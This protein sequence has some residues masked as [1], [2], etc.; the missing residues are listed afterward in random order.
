MKPVPGHI[1]MVALPFTDLSG[2]KRRPVVVVGAAPTGNSDWLVCMVSSK[3]QHRHAAV[4]ELIEPAAPDFPSSGLVAASL[5][6]VGRLAIIEESLLLGAIGSIGA[7]RMNR[8]R[9][10]LKNW[11]NSI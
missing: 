5:V 9:E 11:I 6:R 8:I 7:D 1:A 3:L 2:S 4:D 10:K